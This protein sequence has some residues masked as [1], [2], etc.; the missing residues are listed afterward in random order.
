MRLKA[1]NQDVLQAGWVCDK[2]VPD[3]R[4]LF[5]LPALL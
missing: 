3:N 1:V 5:I 4:F 2:K